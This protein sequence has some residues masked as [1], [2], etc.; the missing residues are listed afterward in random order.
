MVVFFFDHS[1]IVNFDTRVV[2]TR[3]KLNISN[4]LKVIYLCVFTVASLLLR[5]K[6]KTN[7]LPC[8]APFV[9]Q[10]YQQTSIRWVFERST[11]SR[12]YSYATYLLP[13]LN[14][15][16]LPSLVFS[17]EKVPLLRYAKPLRRNRC[18]TS[19]LCDLHVVII[20]GYVGFDDQMSSFSDSK[21]EMYFACKLPYH[22]VTNLNKPFPYITWPC[23]TYKN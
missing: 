21:M 9:I 13:I 14:P 22:I 19:F 16:Y 5:M 11:R 12:V 20:Y 18:D 15:Q 1:P 23:Q 7:A 8:N 4:P 6:Q 10:F 3:L 17:F 2:I